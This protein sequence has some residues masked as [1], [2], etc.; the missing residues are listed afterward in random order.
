M[1]RYTVADGL[2]IRRRSLPSGDVIVTLFNRDGKWRAVARKGKAVGGNLGRLSLF[3]DVTVQYYRRNDNDLALLTQV[4]LNGALPRLSEPQIYPFAHLL[5]E[6]V[7]ELTVDVQLGERMYDYLASGLRGLNRHHDPELVALLYAWRL[8]ALAGLSPNLSACVS[9]GA[10]DSLVG[11]DA[12]AG[13]LCC[14]ACRSGSALGAEVICELRRLV[15]APLRSAL[16]EPITQRPTQWQLL[17]RYLDYHVARLRSLADLSLLLS[18]LQEGGQPGN[19]ATV[20]PSSSDRTQPEA[21]ELTDP[22]HSGGR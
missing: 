12:A 3:H 5:A 13:G 16:E 19:V 6:L 17:S 1:Q 4:Q 8:L 20:G 15:S 9:C 2:V 10:S 21:S 22:A 7:D 14:A 18:G 11:F